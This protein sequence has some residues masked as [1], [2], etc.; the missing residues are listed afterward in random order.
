VLYGNIFLPD[1][2]M[3]SKYA[4]GFFAAVNINVAIAA[5]S[6]LFTMNYRKSRSFVVN[7]TFL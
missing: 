7:F 6:P 4:L 1:T 5:T 3:H 2:A